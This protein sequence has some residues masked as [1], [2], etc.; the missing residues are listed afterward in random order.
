MMPHIQSIPLAVWGAEQVLCK[1]KKGGLIP[2]SN[3]KPFISLQYRL[4]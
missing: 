2:D 3:Q 4:L 1:G